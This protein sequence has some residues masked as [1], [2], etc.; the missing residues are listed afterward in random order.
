MDY[1]LDF[2]RLIKSI[3]KAKSKIDRI[4]YCLSPEFADLY[5]KTLISELKTLLGEDNVK[6]LDIDRLG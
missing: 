3:D 4:E 5:A 6:D 2:S 1:T